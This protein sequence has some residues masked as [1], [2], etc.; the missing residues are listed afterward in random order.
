[1]PST[2]HDFGGFPK[3]L[4]DLEYPAPGAPDY[5]KK[6]IELVRKAEVLADYQRGLDHGTWSVLV[7]MFP[8]ADVPVY[9]LSMDYA[10]PPEYHYELS[11]DLKK[12]RQK[13][14]LIVG[15]GNLVH[16][17]RALRWEESPYDWAVEFD[18]RLTSFIDEGN[19][20]GVIGFSKLGAAAKMAHPTIDH[21]LPLM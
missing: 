13:G 3:E 17:L 15:S 8:K 9:Q 11:Q 14:V 18:S 20:E 19:D 10:K 12:L 6:T 1:M 5:A 7:K 21:L 4:F 16:N 2:I